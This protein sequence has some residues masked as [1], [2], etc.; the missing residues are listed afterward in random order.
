ME[1]VNYSREVANLKGM[2]IARNKDRLTE[3][4]SANINVQSL[5]NAE[6]LEGYPEAKKLLYSELGKTEPQVMIGRL[7]EYAN[8]PFACSIIAAA[9]RAVPGEVL[10]YASSTN[11]LYSNAVRKCNDPLVQTIV[12]IAAESKTPRKSL[13]F[14]SDIHSGKKTI[15]ETD[16]ITSSPDLYFQ[17]LVRLELAND[18]RG[19]STGTD[20]LKHCCLK[21][22]RDMNDLHEA[23]DALR[24]RGIEKFGPEELYYIMLYGVEEIYTSSYT[25]TFNRMM[26]RMK[27]MNG[28]SLLTRVH[29]DHFRTFIRM[30][31]NYGTL[32]AFLA[33]MEDSRKT[34][35]MQQFAANLEQGREDDL[36]DA[37]DVADAYS[38]ISDR[39][40]AAFLRD[41][42]AGNYNRCKQAGLRKGIISYGL[43][44]EVFRSFSGT[45]KGGDFQAMLPAV[46]SCPFR[47][48]Q[49]DSSGI[50]YVQI[51]YYGD[52][53]GRA[54]FNS[55]LNTFPADQWKIERTNYWT[56]ISSKKGKPVVIFA[57][58]P[59]PEPQDEEAQKKLRD[60]L[61]EHDIHPAMV[62]H[63]GHSYHVPLTIEGMQGQNRIIMLG[64]C[65]G[66]HNLGLVLEQAADAQI[67]STKQIGTYKVNKII[68][69]QILRRLKDGEDIYWPQ[70]WNE[71]EEECII[72]GPDVA[73]R[74]EDYVPPH[75]NLGAIFIRAYRRSLLAGS[76]AL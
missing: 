43:L 64:S 1:P 27:G 29:Y 46:S 71:I 52:E 32:S 72:A 12:K 2:I 24:F 48:M 51:F 53:D 8:E 37:V 16:R 62:I 44:S 11:T 58:N 50:V 40:L 75:K 20:E 22:V 69:Q 28:D 33:D 59:L 54:V 23:A 34:A 6:L 42:V 9:A 14:L 30:C 10:T 73:K 76:D 17:S 55:S 70:I 47:A 45:G 35:L 74:F 36:E 41:E 66:F 15:E 25:G 21:Y 13:A 68:I 57:N 7:G 4:I 49:A 60:Y 39:K 18:Q 19:N 56:T 3:F 26:A 61:D 31:A 67:I 38:S 65:G 5:R 63:R